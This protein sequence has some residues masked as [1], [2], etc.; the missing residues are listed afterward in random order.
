V[1]GERRHADIEQSWEISLAESLNPYRS[2]PDH[3]FWRKSIATIP[4]FAI[5]PMTEVPFKIKPTDKV[6]TG[7]SCF[8]QRIAQGLQASGFHY[9]VAEKG[10]EH[11]S[12]EAAYDQGYGVY[13]ARYGN[14]YTTRQLVQLFDRAYGHFKPKL[15]YWTRPDGR[16][17]DPYR[18]QAVPEGFAT[19]DEVIADREPHFAAARRVFEELDVF[20]F[21]FGLTEGWLVKEDGAALQLA[22]GVSGGEFDTDKYVFWNAR[23]HEVAADF[24]A[25]VDRLRSV[26]AKSKII[27][28]VSPVPMIATYENRHVL[29]SNSYTKSALRCAADEVA[30]ARPDISYF[31]SYEMCTGSVNGAQYYTED[32]RTISQTGIN[33]VMKLF[34]DHYTEAK[35]RRSNVRALK[36]D[37]AR[38]TA[39]A[40]KVICDEEA[41]EAA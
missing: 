14:L 20:V 24:I 38:E 7:G 27:V 13:S 16:Y 17:V 30:S 35:S 32:Q 8:A 5:D 39:D 12:P 25:F 36:I 41:I 29:V 15:E 10:P 22:P 9:F 33:V 26:N 21:T 4:P 18:P 6:A 34:F 31:P 37:V 3:R 2:L 40:A 11:L 1:Q 23:P 19:A 28:S